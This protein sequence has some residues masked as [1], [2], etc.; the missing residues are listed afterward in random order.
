M[1]AVC[2][3]GCKKTPAGEM[4]EF[5]ES[6]AERYGEVGDEADFRA[7]EDE[8][9]RFMADHYDV[10]KDD[11]N[12]TDDEVAALIDAIDN[13]D[14]AGRKA[15]ERL[16]ITY[17]DD[18]PDTTVVQPQPSDSTAVQPADSSAAVP[19]EESAPTQDVLSA[20]PTNN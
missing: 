14:E 13:A 19:A 15:A 4:I 18:N 2:L 10:V 3:W 20:Q 1:V 5:Y 16:G 12:L 8:A 17:A 6:L 7:L 9:A 11:D